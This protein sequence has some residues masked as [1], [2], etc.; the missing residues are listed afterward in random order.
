M[1]VPATT[2]DPEFSQKRLSNRAWFAFR[3]RA[4]DY[5][6]E[7]AQHAV[8]F[9][10][11]YEAVPFTRTEFTEKFEALRGVAIL[12]LV[13]CVLNVIRALTDPFYFV[14]AAVLL[15]LAGLSW[16]GYRKLSTTFTVFDAPSGKLLVQ[17]DGQED[18][19]L[20]LIEARRRDRLLDE[21]GDVDPNNDPEM[22][23]RKFG[24]L[25]DHGVITDEEYRAKLAEI[26][27][28]SPESLPPLEGPGGGTVH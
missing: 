2:G 7:D 15:G 19:I 8:R 14:P 3:E 9:Q 27:R 4:L 12:W 16:W 23:R 10:V 11:P 5:R 26:E 1:S 20:S 24:W 17:H 22:E 6:F 21:L 28:A 13:L 25:R 18:E